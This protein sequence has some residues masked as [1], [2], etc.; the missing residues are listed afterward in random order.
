MN[1]IFI[2]VGILGLFIF[3]NKLFEI[4]FNV[5]NICEKV[6]ICKYVVV[7]IIVFFFLINSLISGLFKNKN[8]SVSINEYIILILRVLLYFFFIL[9]NF[10]VLKFCLVKFEIVLFNLLII[11]Y[12]IDFILSFIFWFV[13]VFELKEVIIFVSIILIIVNKIFWNVIGK[14]SFIIFIIF[15]LFILV[16]KLNLSILEDFIKYI[17][18]IIILVINVEMVVFKILNLKV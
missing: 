7:I 18:N 9:L 10:L 16:W 12:I 11:I 8:V 17:M 6:I 15:F 5:L 1:I 3:V 4:I 2:V 14:L 13:I